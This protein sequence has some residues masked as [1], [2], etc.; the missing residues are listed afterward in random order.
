M[1]EQLLKERLFYSLKRKDG[2]IIVAGSQLGGFSYHSRWNTGGTI[3]DLNGL[4]LLFKL[5]NYSRKYLLTGAGLTAYALM[6]LRIIF[7]WL[8]L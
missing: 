3:G 5:W 1:V 6:P 4:R 8:G 7:S 2:T